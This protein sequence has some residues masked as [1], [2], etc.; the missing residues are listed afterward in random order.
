MSKYLLIIPLLLA[1]GAA[2]LADTKMAIGDGL[3]DGTK[4]EPYRHT[5][6]QCSFQNGQPQAQGALVEELVIIGDIVRHRQTG[7]QPNG[8]VSRSDT[9]FDRLSFAPLRM[10]MEATRDGE[11]LAYFER[12]LDEQGY[13]GI[14]MQG[15]KSKELKGLVSSAMLHGGAMGLP[16]ATMDY[17]DESVEFPASMIGFDATYDVIAEWVGKENLEFRDQDFESWMIDVEWRHRESGDVYPPGPDASGGRYWV[18]QNPPDGYPYV[19]RY[20]T[21]T[22]AVEFDTFFCA[23]ADD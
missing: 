17:Q 14:A 11:R 2:A 8:T 4:L 23:A 21:D 1:A 10:E 9:Y 13:T 7:V 18:V 3:I 22:Y 6:Q 20:K 16:L 5:W 15:D 12:E 19:P